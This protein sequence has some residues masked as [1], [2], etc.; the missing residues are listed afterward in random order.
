MRSCIFVLYL[1]SPPTSRFHRFILL[2]WIIH[3]MFKKIW[4]G[5]TLWPC[6][7]VMNHVSHIC[8][9]RFIFLTFCMQRRH[10]LFN[11][12]VTCQKKR[13]GLWENTNTSSLPP[14]LWWLYC[15]A[16]LWPVWYYRTHYVLLITKLAIWKSCL[17][18][19]FD[20]WELGSHFQ[21]TRANHL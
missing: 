5:L 6:F 12:N 14:S 9:F 19:W 21:I 7:Y 11:H 18:I 3:L 17:L 13:S 10:V 2:E 1:K 4:L 15:F 8:S 16:V 20:L